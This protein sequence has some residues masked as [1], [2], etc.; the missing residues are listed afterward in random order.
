MN[1]FNHKLSLVMVAYTEVD[2]IEKVLRHYHDEIFMR[3]PRGS[4]FIVYLDGSNDGTAEVVAGLKKEFNLTVIDCKVNKGYFIAAKTALSNARNE[5]VFFS[6]SSGKHNPQDF[7]V[8]AELIDDFDVVNGLRIGRTDIF[9]R[10]LLSFFHR[11]FVSILFM[12]PLH[13]Y[14]SGFK[15]IRKKVLDDVLPEC[16]TLP[17]T[18]STEFLIRAYAKGYK[19][20]DAPVS[21]SHRN[22]EERQFT[23]KKIPSVLWRQIKAYAKLRLELI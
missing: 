22:T 16:S 15:L 12:M 3:A 19:I 9:Y 17:V 13:D 21:F 11:F 6:D 7:W 10:R 14:N 2:I 5:I 8:L 18:F 20:A 4:E 23:L 1:R